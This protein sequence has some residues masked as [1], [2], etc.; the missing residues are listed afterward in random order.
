[1]PC[2]IYLFQAKQL[3]LAIARTIILER[4]PVPVVARAIDVLVTSYMSSLKTGNYHKGTKAEKASP[5]GVSNT[6]TPVEDKTETAKDETTSSMQ[7]KCVPRPFPGSGSED[8]VSYGTQRSEFQDFDSSTSVGPEVHS[9][10]VK[11]Q[12]VGTCSTPLNANIPEQQESRV[13]SAAI[14]LDDL[15][16]YVFAPVEEEMAGDASYLV[17]IIIEVLRRYFAL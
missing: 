4:R 17:A 14:S 12:I 1:M 3:C 16:S 7:E 6:R 11:S 13:T 2:V 10:A 8:N 5:S 15:Y 9:S